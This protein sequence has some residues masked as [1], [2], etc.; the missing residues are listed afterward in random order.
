VRRSVRR[1]IRRE[2]KRTHETGKSKTVGNA[3]DEDAG[4]TESR[5][6]DV[7]SSVE[8]HDNTDDEIERSD[9]S[10]GDEDGFGGIARLLHLTDNGEVGGGTG[11][12]E[13]LP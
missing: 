13:K 6:C 7:L 8:V 3:L 12:G 1:R 10:L 11:V 9:E 5:G 4:G 2:E